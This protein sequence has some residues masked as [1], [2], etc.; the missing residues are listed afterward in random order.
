MKISDI[1]STV[2]EYH[3]ICLFR[4]IKCFTEKLIFYSNV[5]TSEY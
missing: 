2:C 3:E 1:F 4:S 5:Y